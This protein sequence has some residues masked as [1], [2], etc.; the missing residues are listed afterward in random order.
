[1]NGCI[2][3]EVRSV[4]RR[5][6]AIPT[7]RQATAI[8]RGSCADADVG[9]CSIRYFVILRLDKCITL[10]GAETSSKLNGFS[11]FSGL[12]RGRDVLSA[13]EVYLNDMRYINSRYT[14]LLTY[15]LMFVSVGL[16]ALFCSFLTPDAVH[17]VCMAVCVSVTLM[18]CAKTTKRDLHQLVAQAF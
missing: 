7:L 1:V 9:P 18:Y 3:Y 8:K 4:S 14:Y 12:G 6:M 11:L 2:T 16:D 13:L 5:Q 15:L 10:R 17:A